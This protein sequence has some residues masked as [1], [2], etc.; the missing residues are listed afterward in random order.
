MP[1]PIETLLRVH[2]SPLPTQIF[3]EFFGSIAI[4]PIDCTA[5]S[6]NTGRKRVPASSDFQMP[7]LAAPTKRVI[8][9]EGSFTPSTAEI[10]P[11]IAADPILRAPSPEMVAELQGASFV[12]EADA[13]TRIEQS[14]V[15]MRKRICYFAVGNLKIASSTV[16][17]G[18]A[19][20]M[21]IF[22][23]SGPPLRPDS[24]E[25]GRKTPAIFS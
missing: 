7:P 4:A 18:S 24:M 22:C 20:S 13:L 6:S 3:L 15:G 5:C 21:T 1:S 9:P 19:L 16:M 2:D 12:P 8:L 11:L 17:L 10:R 14:K 23:L 25:N